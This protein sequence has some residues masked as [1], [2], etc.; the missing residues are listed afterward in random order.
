[1]VVLVVLAGY[2]NL[3]IAGFIILLTDNGFVLS[4]VM[5]NIVKRQFENGLKK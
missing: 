3:I 1:M 4:E 2:Q 5:M